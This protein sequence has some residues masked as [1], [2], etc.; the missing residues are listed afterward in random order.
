[1]THVLVTSY[2][3]TYWETYLSTKDENWVLSTKL[4]HQ[5]NWDMS[6]D[7]YNIVVAQGANPRL[8][9]FCSGDNEV[10]LLQRARQKT[11]TTTRLTMVFNIVV[12]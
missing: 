12:D 3:Q 9:T 1:M 2:L 7:K 5:P 11:I 4:S 6:Q 10:V 8:A